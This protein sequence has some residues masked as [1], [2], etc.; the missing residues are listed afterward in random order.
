MKDRPHLPLTGAALQHEGGIHRKGAMGHVVVDADGE[1]MGRRRSGRSAGGVGRQMGRQVVEHRLGHRRREL[2]GG[3]PVAPAEHHGRSDAR[4]GDAPGLGKGHEHVL[5]QGFG[6][7]A[8]LLAAIEHRQ[9]PHRRRQRPGQG[10]RRKGPKQANFQQPHPFTT[11]PQRLHR[12]FQHTAGRTH[13]H[14]HPL[15]IRI[16]HVLH[17]SV[18][19]PTEGGET[20]H[21]LGHVIGQG[22]V[23][24]DRV[25]GDHLTEAIGDARHRLVA[26]DREGGGGDHGALGDGS[27]GGS[28]S[29]RLRARPTCTSTRSPT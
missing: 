25:K 24:R 28:S 20:L 22:V 7:R 14:H 13:R 4:P 26:I 29:T 5:S 16:P 11:V 8:G 9:R 15:G 12:V 21:R 10:S 23:M 17:Q 3:Q 6:Q 1:G 19:A 18:P 2:L 27:C